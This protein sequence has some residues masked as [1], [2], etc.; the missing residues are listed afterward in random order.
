MAKPQAE[1]GHVDIANEIAEALCRINLTAYES[2]IL[3]A[4]FRKT[5]G[6]H[7]KWDRISYT[8][9][10]KMTGINR[11]HI[12]RTIKQLI[13]RNIIT[14]R[15]NGYK[16]EYTFQKDYEQ[17]K[18]VFHRNDLL[19]SGVTDKQS[20]P[21]GEKPLP[22]G[23][24]KSLPPGVN[25]KEKKETRQKKVDKRKYGE[26]NNVFLTDEEYHKLEERFGGAECRR[27]IEVLSSGMKSKKKYKYD[28]HYAAILS[29]K[30]REEKE[31]NHEPKLGKDGWPRSI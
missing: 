11:W 3:W 16:I 2:R 27:M 29:W 9:W 25:T 22:S 12:A 8:Q 30:R 1:N 15:G 20:L 23:V 24:T 5:Y 21:P 19:P 31:Q 13:A 18:M 14:Q 7:K 4:L 10:E 6:W 26:F 17:W 28:S